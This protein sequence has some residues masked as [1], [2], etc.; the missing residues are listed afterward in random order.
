MFLPV[1][2]ILSFIVIISC[3]QI[4]STTSNK[5]TNFVTFM[6]FFANQQYSFYL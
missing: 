2:N 4:L 3:S 5:R 1:L 6:A